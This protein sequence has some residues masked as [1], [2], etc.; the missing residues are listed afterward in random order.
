MDRNLRNIRSVCFLNLVGNGRDL[1]LLFRHGAGFT[2]PF[3]VLKCW[4][5]GWVINNFKE[6][7]NN[8]TLFKKKNIRKSDF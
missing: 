2:R 7:I 3:F 5:R 6:V 1:D 8:L 4:C